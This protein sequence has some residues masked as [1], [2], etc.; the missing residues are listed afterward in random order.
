MTFLYVSCVVVSL[1]FL[2]ESA[3][4]SHKRLRLRTASLSNVTPTGAECAIKLSSC[5]CPDCSKAT[6]C[7][8]QMISASAALR[9]LDSSGI[10]PAQRWLLG[11]KLFGLWENAQRDCSDSPRV[12]LSISRESQWISV[13][14]FRFVRSLGLKWGCFV[15]R[16]IFYFL[17]LFFAPDWMQ[18]SWVSKSSFSEP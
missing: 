7:Q 8:S 13:K 1:P 2:S 3:R 4:V 10:P 18:S 5:L 15:R 16:R 14:L 9:S 11:N 6:F 17:P 12:D